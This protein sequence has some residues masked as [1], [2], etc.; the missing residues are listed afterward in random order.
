MNE[1]IL[2]AL[3]HLFAMVSDSENGN[4]SGNERTIVMDYLD[5]QYSHELV[6]T[7]IDYFDQQVKIFHDYKTHLLNTQ[8]E[9]N[10]IICQVPHL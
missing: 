7:Y 8:P 5:L 6:L 10:Q 9:Q 2:K 4:I 1:S 3:I